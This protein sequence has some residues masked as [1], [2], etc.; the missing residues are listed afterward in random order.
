M[1]NVVQP[2]RELKLNQIKSSTTNDKKYNQCC[3][4]T[5]CGQCCYVASDPKLN[6]PFESWEEAK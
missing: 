4:V 3:S 5:C 6:K 2:H 1:L